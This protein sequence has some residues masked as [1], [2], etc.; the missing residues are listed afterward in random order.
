M[1]TGD[2]PTWATLRTNVSNIDPSEYAGVP[3]PVE[4]APLVVAPGHPW[5]DRLNG[6]C[7]DKAKDR[8][9]FSKSDRDDGVECINR[10][11]DWHG[12]RDVY[13]FR[14][15]GS[16]SRV[17]TMPVGPMQRARTMFDCLGV[18]L[19]MDIEAEKRA[20]DLLRGMIPSHLFEVYQLTGSFIETSKRS[21]VV[22]QFR[23]LATTIA[24]S[25]GCGEEMRFLAALC[26]HPIAFYE[27][28]PIGAMV[29]TDDVIAHL[30]LMRADEH[31]FW[32]KAN[33]HGSFSPGAQL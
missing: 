26:L 16:R 17:A 21:G 18:A 9:A 30:T 20:M 27:G 33:Q 32:R 11:H 12:R 4:M 7:L 14:D 6:V 2:G 13:V 19:T 24:W 29:P 23:R 15:K 1:V 5:H 28:L 8:S 3:T 31:M 25:A 22:Y 10:W